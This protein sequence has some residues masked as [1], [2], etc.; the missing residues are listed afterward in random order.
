MFR[1]IYIV[2][3]AFLKIYQICWYKLICHYFIRLVGIYYMNDIHSLT[4]N[5]IKPWI[6]SILYRPLVYS[7]NC[8]SIEKFQIHNYVWWYIL[9]HHFTSI[10]YACINI[11][12]NL[13]RK[14]TPGRG[15][16]SIP[17]LRRRTCVTN[18]YKYNEYNLRIKIHY[19][20]TIF[21][22]CQ[23]AF[24]DIIGC[25]TFDGVKAVLTSYL[26]VKT[27]VLWIIYMYYF[28]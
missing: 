25:N 10:S 27:I 3:N 1:S 11:L 7:C 12:Y 21:K 13:R 5:V 9:S 18:M 19:P 28:Y 24:T 15:G 4:Y 23:E 8:R 14:I 2:L 20:P 6:V 17:L 16:H 26:E 22:S